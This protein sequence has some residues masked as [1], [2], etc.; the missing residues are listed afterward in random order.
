MTPSRATPLPPAS[1]PRA[2][3]PRPTRS[4][5]SLTTAQHPDQPAS[6]LGGGLVRLRLGVQYDGT[7]FHGWAH[8]PGLRTVQ[9]EL[10]QAMSTVLREPVHLTVA[11]R[12]DA[13]VHAT[14]QVVHCDVSRSAWEDQGARL[15]D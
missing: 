7:A 3:T 11:G 2:A 1:S 13:G 14:G 4:D 9:A 12:T 5:P 10:E 6:D 15:L 8:Q